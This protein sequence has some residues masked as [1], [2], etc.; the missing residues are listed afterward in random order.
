MLKTEKTSSAYPTS[1]RS[2]ILALNMQGFENFRA[3]LPE[4]EAPGS[5][6]AQQEDTSFTPDIT[7]MH[8][9]GHKGYFEIAQKTTDESQLARKW[10]L[11]SSMAKARNGIF[12]VFV[13]SGHMRFTQNLVSRYRLDLEIAKL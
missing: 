12:K 13:P 7:A 5:L 8:R 4:Y 2:V 3:E 10:E 11:L 1:V 6:V 9:D